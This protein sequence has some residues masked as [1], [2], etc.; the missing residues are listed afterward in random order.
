MNTSLQFLLT[1]PY[2]TYDGVSRTVSTT[3][4]STDVSGTSTASYLSD[5][6]AVELWYDMPVSDI[7]IWNRL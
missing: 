4:S 1:D 7:Y 6:F 5:T 2:Y 3:I